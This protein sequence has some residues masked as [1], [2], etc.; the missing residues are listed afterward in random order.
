[1][2]APGLASVALVLSI[3]TW[4]LLSSVLPRVENP[5]PESIGIELPFAL[6]GAFGVAAGAWHADAPREKRDKAV[7]MGGAWGFRV[8]ALLYAL[9]LVNQVTFGL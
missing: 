7:A 9:A 2:R 5:W 3:W 8:G 4:L 1:M 6:A